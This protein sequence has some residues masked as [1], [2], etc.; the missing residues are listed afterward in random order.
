MTGTVE[1]RPPSRRGSRSPPWLKC[2]SRR[3]HFNRRP[4]Q[5]SPPAPASVAEPAAPPSPELDDSIIANRLVEM[6]VLTPY[7]AGQIKGGRTI[8]N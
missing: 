5:S 2:Q 7:Q 1:I 4:I 3:R 6:G 8:T